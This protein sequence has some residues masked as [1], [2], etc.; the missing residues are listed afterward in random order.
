MEQPLGVPGI[1]GLK[2]SFVVLSELLSD[3]FLSNAGG[4]HETTPA[5]RPSA[6]QVVRNLVDDDK[7]PEFC[8]K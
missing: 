1:Y 4:D 7:Y 6:T 8:L 5:L 3:R 2:D